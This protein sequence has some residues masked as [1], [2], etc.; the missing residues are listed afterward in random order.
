MPTVVNPVIFQALCVMRQTIVLPKCATALT[1]SPLA[2]ATSTRTAFTVNRQASW[3]GHVCRHDRLPKIIL[4]GTVDGSRC[5][6]RPRKSWRDNTSE[7]TGQSMSS[8]LRIADDRCRCDSR[9]HSGCIG[10]SAPTMPGRT[11]I[12]Q[13]K[14]VA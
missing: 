7:W 3:F 1:P 12:S 4:Q 11:G 9:H 14:Y 2:D 13:L 5:R 6:E 8:L 10:R